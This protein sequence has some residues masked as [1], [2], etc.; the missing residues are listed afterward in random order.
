MKMLSSKEPWQKALMLLTQL[1]CARKKLGTYLESFAQDGAY[2]VC[3]AYVLN[4]VKH[5]RL[6]EYFLETHTKKLPKRELKCFLLLVVGQ[7][8]R[9]FLDK[10]LTKDNIPPLVNGWI[11]RAKV[12]FIKD[13]CR[14]INAILRKVLPF[15]EGADALPLQIRYNMP[16]FFIERYKRYYGEANLQKY[17]QWN[18]SFSKVY[19]RTHE[20]ISGLKPTVWK[21][22][23]ELTEDV[24]WQEVLTVLKTGKLYVQDP[25]TRIPV[26]QLDVQLGGNVLDLCA[27]PGGK[28]VQ[29][30]QKLKQTGCIVSV[31]LPNHMKRLEENTKFYPQVRLIGKDILALQKEDFREN[32]LPECF[33]RVLIDVPCSNT[34]VAR[35]KPDVLN[36][37]KSEDFNVLPKIQFEL[38]CKASIFVKKNGLLVYSTCSID[39]EENDGVVKAFLKQHEDFSLLSSHVSLPWEDNHDGGGAFCMKKC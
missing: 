21:D 24:C 36:R 27:A 23:Y 35:R 37:L 38:L 32:N 19:V 1:E 10:D 6:L 22:F 26:E 3:R 34:G 30:A 13:E 29:I 16:T 5:R 11:E 20:K 8:W 33:D 31:D 2:A 25:M 39:P 4:V 14:F 15:F 17:L 28:T 18:E 9:K 12:L 7:M